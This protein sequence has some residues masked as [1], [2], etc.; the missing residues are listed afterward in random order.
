MS[1]EAFCIG[2]IKTLLKEIKCNW[3]AIINALI[4]K[5]KMLKLSHQGTNINNLRVQKA[6]KTLQLT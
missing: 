2:Q 5:I 1:L 3:L 6:Q 4:N